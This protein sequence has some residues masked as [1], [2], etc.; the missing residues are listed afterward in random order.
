M[1]QT[2]QKDKETAPLPRHSP[3]TDSDKE[4]AG[5]DH[6][7]PASVGR[8]RV[9]GLLGRGHGAGWGDSSLL[10]TS[11]ARAD[12]GRH[13]ENGPGL[14]GTWVNGHLRGEREKKQAERE[15][16]H[17]A[18]A[19]TCMAGRGHTAPVSFISE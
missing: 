16:G 2:G 8:A 6:P 15:S 3:G 10:P 18:R 19:V 11:V 14:S 4:A 17:I 5:N 1:P 7:P 13:A 12:S 9:P